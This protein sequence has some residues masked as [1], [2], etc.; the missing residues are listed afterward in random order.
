MLIPSLPPEALSKM[1]LWRQ[2]GGVC[3]QRIVEPLPHQ[4]QNCAG[5]EV[6][7][8]SFCRA[9]AHKYTGGGL[10]LWFEGDQGVPGGWYKIEQTTTFPCPKCTMLPAAPWR[11]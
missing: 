2:Q 4:C 8:V 11:G 5:A 1:A 9:G 3:F 10:E 7:Y 6:V